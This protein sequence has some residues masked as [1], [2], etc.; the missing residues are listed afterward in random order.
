MYANLFAP[1][2]DD[3]GNLLDE[4]GN[5]INEDE[6]EYMFDDDETTIDE[7][8]SRADRLGDRFRD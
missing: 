1:D 2:Y 7:Y 4:D 3:E 6:I 8:I 5:I